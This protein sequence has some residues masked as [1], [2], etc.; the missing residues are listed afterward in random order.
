MI[1]KT[2]NGTSLASSNSTAD[3]DR[4]KGVTK[5]ACGLPKPNYLKQSKPTN[6]TIIIVAM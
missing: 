4:G 2:S 3:E 1:F 5:G 6:K